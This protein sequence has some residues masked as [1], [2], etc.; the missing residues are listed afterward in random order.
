MKLLL[1]GVVLVAALVVVP[2]MS[3]ELRDLD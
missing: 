3:E 2:A 1:V